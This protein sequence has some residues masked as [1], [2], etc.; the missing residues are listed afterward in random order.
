MSRANLASMAWLNLWRNRR[1]T[2]LT[3]SSISFGVMLAILFTGLGDQNWREMI[4]LAAR[5]GGGHVSIQNAEYLD[6]PLLRHSVRESTEL[7]EMA[8]EDEEVLRAVTRISGQIM[9]STAGKSY[10]A[11]FIGIDPLEEDVETLSLIEAIDEGEMLQ[12]SRGNQII[13]GRRLAENLGVRLKSKVIYTLTDPK[14]EIIYGVARV[15][16]ILTTGAPTVDSGLSILPIDTL[17]ESL[18]MSEGEGTQIALFLDDHREADRVAERLSAG[19]PEDLA[20][21]PWHRT[22]PE[23]AGFI[24]MKVA[25]AQLMEFVI[26]VLIAAGIFN[27]LFVS[28]MERLREFGVMVAIGF[29]PGALF[30]LVMLESLWLGLLGLIGAAVVTAAPYHFLS[31]TG[32]DISEQLGLT[33][34]EVAGVALTSVMRVGIY[35]ENALIIGLAALAGTLLSAIYPAW[36]AGRVAPA[37]TVRLV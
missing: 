19:L 7:R 25:G 33:G 35:P 32:I 12:S 23:L 36:R 8:V 26:M 18:G 28:V 1:R 30:A 2:L 6:T 14:G 15:S 21:L 5:L 3:L 10:G 9:L 13:L 31:T 34:T 20:V 11:G 29:S 22:Q 27:T 17:R 4:D 37:E 16:G 24:A